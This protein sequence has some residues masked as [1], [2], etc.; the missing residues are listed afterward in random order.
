MAIESLRKGDLVEVKSA[1]EILA[2]LDERGAYEGLPFMLEMVAYAGQRLVVDV[3]ADKICDTVKLTGSRTLPD[4]VLLGD[5]R[6]NGTGHGGCQA[7]CRL[8]FK[9]VWLKRV[10]PEEPPPAPSDAAAVAALTER[11]SR[12]ITQ[13]VEIDGKREECWSCQATRLFDATTR[14][15]TFNPVPYMREYTNG[16]VPLGR[17][18]RVAARAVV[19]EP[20]R[21]FGLTPKVFLKGKGTKSGGEPPLNLQPGELVQVKSAE[22]IAATPQRERPQP[23]PLVRSGDDSLLRKDLPR[24]QARESLHRRLSRRPHGRAQDRS[25]HSRGRRVH[26][27]PQPAALVLPPQGHSVLARVLAAQSRGRAGLIRRSGGP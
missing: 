13:M 15:S 20:M 19:E 26:R 3:R 22:E 9:S 11:V 16:N 23:R 6:C 25:H 18:V 8:Y 27:G 1:A 21:K 14:V 2:T 5:L 7:E 12:Q 24:A 10:R 4:S 17:F